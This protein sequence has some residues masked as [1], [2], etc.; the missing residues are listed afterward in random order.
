MDE[1]VRRACRRLAA[2]Q[3]PIGLDVFA[4]V[5]ESSR[6]QAIAISA[7]LERN[8]LV[9]LD[10]EGRVNMLAPVRRQVMALAAG[11]DDPAAALAGI[12]RW[13]DRALPVGDHAGLANAPW[14]AEMD[15]LTRAVAA[16]CADRDTLDFGYGLA[17]RAFGALYTAMRPREALELLEIPLAAGEGPPNVGAQAARRAA[18]AA[19]E[20][21]GTFEG[22]SFLDR[23]EAHAVRCE[24]PTMQLAAC[25]SIRAEMLL[26]AG[27]L[28]DAFTEANRVFS[29][30]TD[31]AAVRQ[32]RRT[33]MDVDVSRGNFLAAERLAPLIIDGAPEEERWVAIASRLLLGTIAWEQGRALEAAAVARSAR[34]DA[35]ALDE[36]RVA[37]LADILYRR[38]TGQRGEIAP[39]IEQLPWAVRLGYQSQS[40]REALAAGDVA[41]AAGLAADTIVLGDSSRL[42]RDGIEAR[43]VLADALLAQGDSVQA[44]STYAVA[45][46]R[47][48][49]CPLPLRAADAL[50]G[51]AVALASTRPGLAAKCAGAAYALRAPRGAVRGPR[52][53]L[54]LSGIPPMKAPLGWVVDGALTQ[55]GLAAIARADLG[56]E[57]EP[58]LGAVAVLTKGQLAVAELVGQGMT[59]KEIA[60]R[61]YLSPRTVDNH[62][63]QIY[64]RLAIPSR[65]HLAILMANNG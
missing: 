64:R 3:V 30:T 2:M 25:A 36:N 34:E 6:V 37:L 44:M 61:L 58:S 29:L 16:V 59:S 35:L 7:L 55:D 5:I 24:D 8:S 20:V 23:G 10:V 62:L 1:H 31:G 60:Q 48:V 12:I 15:T 43:I 22:L 45:V 28:D 63:A 42:E 14:L 9:V 38:V 26:D 18:I 51:I 54:D 47:A 49:A 17:N 50:D 21:R 11:S 32:A 56:A 52:P 40:A 57:S 13:A 33:C 46:R 27:Q 65:A 53:G 39:D 4:E 41:R 19:S